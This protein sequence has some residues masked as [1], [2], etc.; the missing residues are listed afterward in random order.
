MVVATFQAKIGC[1]RLKR[2]ENKN[3]CSVS[4]LPTRNVKFQKNSKKCE[5]I[6]KYH[7]GLISDQNRLE[8]SE[9]EEK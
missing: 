3:Y 4:F 5:K 9:K 7:Y 6:K 2:I 1:K 8:K